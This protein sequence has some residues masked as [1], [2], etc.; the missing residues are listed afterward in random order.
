MAQTDLLTNRPTF[1]ALAPLADQLADASVGQLFDADPDRVHKY[2]AAAAGLH[3]DYSKHLLDDAARA[4]LLALADEVDL[5]A[6]A[7]ALLRGDQVNNTE[8]R[9][10]LHTLLRAN[11]AAGLDA[12]YQEVT[13]T[14]ERMRYWAN[15]LNAGEQTGFSG[16]VIT[17]VVNI[18]IGGSDLGPRLVTEALRPFQGNVACHYVANV[19][20]A[21]LHDTLAELNPHTTLFIICSKSFK[22]QETLTNGLAARDWLIRAGAD[23]TQL[24]RHFL[25]MTTNLEAAAG[26][27][28]APEQCL[29]LW[30]WVGGRY[31]VWSAVGLSCAIAVGWAN[32]E[33]FLGG[34]RAMDEHFASAPPESNLPMLLSLLEVW[35]GN[36]MGAENHVV[37]PYDNALQRLPDFLQ[38]LTMESNGKRV[39]RSGS[40]ITY[41]TG[42][43]LWG[44]AG[45]MGQHSF[46]QLL[47]QGTRLCPADFIL[48]LTTHTGM[49]EQHAQLVANCLAQSRAMMIG[50]TLEE[51]EQALRQRGL[52]NDEANSLAPHLAMP[53]S[54]P[55]STISFESVNPATLGALLAL[56]EHRTY[57]SGQLW[58]VNPFDQW[59]VELGKEIGVQILDELNG[60]SED[61]AMDPSTQA[62]ISRWRQAK[63]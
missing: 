63:Q 25:A 31:S 60:E 20:P 50:R 21:D 42:P 29:P 54:R 26:F 11:K 28:I 10:A 37:L 57:C 23:T 59:G 55:N 58:G 46:H 43:V 8:Q 3:L 41:Q 15:R 27:G 56:Y 16:Q 51:A 5:P 45:T 19:D 44:S 13:S 35:Y 61:T 34:A 62:L 47:H 18:G 9:P 22:T 32:F 40:E 39:T 48:P 24:T 52:D 53:G 12:L 4:A 36:A 38:Q 14:R 1:K 17:D 2:S 30:D 6:R 33:A 49:E 7:A